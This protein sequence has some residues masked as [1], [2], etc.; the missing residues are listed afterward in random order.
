MPSILAQCTGLSCLGH[1]RELITRNSKNSVEITPTNWPVNL[2]LTGTASLNSGFCCFLSVKPHSE[3]NIFLCVRAESS[4][5]PLL[6]SQTTC[7][8]PHRCDSCDTGSIS[9][10]N[11]TR[12]TNISTSDVKDKMIGFQLDCTG[13]MTKACTFLW[14]T[15]RKT[16]FA[17]KSKIFSILSTENLFSKDT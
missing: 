9:Y 16:C 15:H 3:E 14:Y 6:P 17:F 11:N 1:L 2:A 10:M 8:Y 12:T 5:L 4:Q 7:C 13:I